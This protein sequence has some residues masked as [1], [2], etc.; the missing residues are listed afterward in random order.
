MSSRFKISFSRL[1][2]DHL[3][4]GVDDGVLRFRKHYIDTGRVLIKSIPERA[5][6]YGSNLAHSPEIVLPRSQRNNGPRNQP[7][8]LLP[9]DSIGG[10]LYGEFNGEYGSHSSQA[11]RSDSDLQ[12]LE[13]G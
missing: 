7:S 3:E 2:H 1:D 12:R 4:I 8:G 9:Q 10:S 13:S 6:D 11:N 5:L